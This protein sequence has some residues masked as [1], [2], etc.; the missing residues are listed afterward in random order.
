MELDGNSDKYLY[1]AKVDKAIKRPQISVD[2]LFI[3]EISYL[4]L[5]YSVLPVPLLFG[6]GRMQK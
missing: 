6:R 5:L 4:I 3:T 1:P 2:A